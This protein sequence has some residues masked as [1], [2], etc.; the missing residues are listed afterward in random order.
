MSVEERLVELGLELPQVAQ[1]AAN[2]QPWRRVGRFLVVSGQLAFVDG[3]L[4]GRGKVGGDVSL[5]EGR[6]HARLAALN[7]LAAIA[8]GADNI[9]D[10]MVTKLSVYVASVTDFSDQHLVADGASDLMVGVLGDPGL[11]A[12]VVIAVPCLPLNASVEVQVD[13]YLGAG[14]GPSSECGSL[15]GALNS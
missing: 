13:C 10:I 1:P 7:C 12:R 14:A 6:E 15:V 3:D 9:N 4:R 2:Y 8:A 11:H 5:D